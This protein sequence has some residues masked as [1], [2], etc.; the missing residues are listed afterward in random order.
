MFKKTE[1]KNES[2]DLLRKINNDAHWIG[3]PAPDFT[4]RDLNGDEV[5]LSK[6]KGK[7]VAL[8]FWFTEC[9]PC[10]VEMQDLNAL[11]KKHSGSVVFLGITFDNP[12][13]VNALLKTTTFNYQ[14]IPNA[15]IICN[16]WNI[17]GYPTNIVIDKKGIV[18]YVKV[19]WDKNIGNLLNE[20]IQNH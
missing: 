15:E 20:A 1:V 14:I 4:A 17:E 6:L 3:K 11:Q 13:K 16:D 8:N 10:I 9:K 2:S 5:Q 7:V 12:E 18:R 19:G